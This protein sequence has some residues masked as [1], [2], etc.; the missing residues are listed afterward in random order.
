MLSRINRRNRVQS[1]TMR[2][3]REPLSARAFYPDKTDRKELVWDRAV[4]DLRSALRG[5]SET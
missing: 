3:T 4:E 5:L 2:R 1:L